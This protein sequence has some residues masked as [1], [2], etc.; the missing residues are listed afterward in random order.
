MK[1]I[2]LN[3]AAFL[4][5]LSA[6][7]GCRDTG[8]NDA[9]DGRLYYTDSN[10]PSSI[11][12]VSANDSN[13]GFL[14]GAVNNLQYTGSVARN[15]ALRGQGYI[16]FYN[17]GVSNS[18]LFFPGDDSPSFPSPLDTYTVFNAAVSPDQKKI[19]YAGAGNNY[20]IFNIDTGIPPGITAPV[21]H[22]AGLTTG[23]SWSNDSNKVALV[24][25]PYPYQ[26]AAWNTVNNDVILIGP[27]GASNINP[28]WSPDGKKI[29]FSSDAN[30]GS[31]IHDVFLSEADG[32]G[33]ISLTNTTP[34]VETTPV[35]SPDGRQI[36]YLSQSGGPDSIYVINSDGS[37]NRQVTQTAGAIGC[38]Q[39]SWSYY[40]TKIVFLA[41]WTGTNQVYIVEPDGSNLVQHSTSSGA[42][43][44]PVWLDK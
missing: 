19:A 16:F 26:I 1:K 41:D 13:D 32:S 2:L 12:S 38:S 30:Y 43:T 29:V 11:V 33:W 8:N 14:I 20:F 25:E 22:D 28:A 44:N 39:I 42:K 4:L 6:L 21:T 17:P 36:A 3:A 10:Y 24:Y 37:E 15:Y 9:E 5:I 35:W 18:E 34:A 23:I 31:N 40:G 7:T 27:S